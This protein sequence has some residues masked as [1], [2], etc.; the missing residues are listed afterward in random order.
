M[1]QDGVSGQFEMPPPVFYA[2]H[3]G[4]KEADHMHGCDRP[5]IET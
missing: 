3:K 4:R 1:Q 2:K 5:Q